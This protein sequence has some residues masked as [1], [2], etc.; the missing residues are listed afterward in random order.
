[1]RSPKRG[2]S[3]TNPVAAAEPAVLHPVPRRR[4]EVTHR[5]EALI[6]LLP[7]ATLVVDGSGRIR[8][9]NRQTEQLFGYSA[10]ELLDQPVELLVPEQLRTVHRQHRTDYVAA[11]HARPMGD[12]LLLSG[13]RRDGTE[14]PLKASLGPLDESNESLVIVSIH[15]MSELYRVQAASEVANRALGALQ[16]LTDTAL[17]NLTL[18]NLL[19][20]LLVRV[21]DAMS[22]DEAAILLVEETPEGQ[23]LALQAALGCEDTDNVRIPLGQG[24][25]GS[26]AASRAP[27]AVDDLTTFPMY[28]SALR[29]DVCSAVGVPLLVEDRLLGVVQARTRHPHH[30]TQQD[31]QLLQQ[32]A[33]RIALAIDRA[34]LYAG[35]QQARQALGEQVEQLDR[36]FEHISDGLV[37]YNAQGQPVRLNAAARRILGL[38][39][40]PSEYG[41]LPASD[42]AVL[43]EA[44]DVQGRRLEPQEWPLIRVLSGRVAGADTLEVRLRI[45]DGREVEV[46]S[47]AA[48]IRDGNGQLVGAVTILHD[49]TEQKRLAREREEARAHE[50]ALEDIARHMDEFLATASHDLRTPLTV[51]KSQVQLALRRFMR[52]RESATARTTEALL[53]ADLETLHTS[54][55]EANQSADRLTRLVAVL[56]DVARARSGTLEL[57]LAPFDLADLVRRT[58]AAQQGAVP[59]RSIVLEATEAV[60]AVEADADR[61]DQVLSNYLTN[62]LK[63]SQADQPVTVRLEVVEDQAVVSVADHGPGLPL[64]E[65]SRIWEVYH[66]VPGIEVQPGNSEISGSLGLGLHICKQLIELHPGGRI[67]VESTVGEGSTFWFRLPLVS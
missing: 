1:M 44:Y 12:S 40:A 65:Q 20:E 54:L 27:L 55:V 45:L 17:S 21:V 31:V 37:V 25:V 43:Y 6:Q 52:L 47:S 11:P 32:A 39:A 66:R 22:V 35:E 28:Y 2:T 14:F 67:G 53:E 63:Y 60:V 24:F 50:L 46:I 58:V 51:V 61:L 34:R 64:E 29:R 49:Q 5:F 23:I 13:R 26:V 3:P 62:A 15:D 4:R 38:D 16:A 42:R 30:F 57:E 7:D 41:Q 9:V 33:D 59:E 36:I 48:P 10:E 56:F 8:L 18:D 19:D